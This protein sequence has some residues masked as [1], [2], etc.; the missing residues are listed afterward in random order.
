MNKKILSAV[1]AAVMIVTLM[2]CSA[3]GAIK[4]AGTASKT[5]TLISSE[6][7][8]HNFVK[9]TANRSSLDVEVETPIKA[10]EFNAS[11]VKA[12]KTGSS[13]VCRAYPADMDGYYSFDFSIPLYVSRAGGNLSGDYILMITMKKTSSS[14]SVVCYK[15][16]AF[17]VTDGKFSIL[18]YSDIMKENSR[19]ETLGAKVK[20]SN[21]KK[22]N[23]SDLK[24]LVFKDPVTKKV[25][26]VTTSKV[27]YFKKVADS[28]TKGARTDYDKVLK[29]YEY[30]GTNFYYDTVAF[31]TKTKQYVDPY[32]NLYNM[33]NKKTSNNSKSGKVA[34]T[35][36][37]YAA[38]VVALCRAEGIPAR[39][40]NGHHVSLGDGGFNNWST[41]SGITT[42]DHWWAEA[43]IDGRWIIVDTTPAN[44]NKWNRTTNKWTYTGLTNYIYF[45]PT[46]EQFATSH[47]TFQIKGVN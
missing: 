1:L 15:N 44:S 22:T 21:F 39:V 16:C 19:I 12:G 29:I 28:V 25:A 47:L 26:S 23:M 42:L 36:V 41:E 10:S 17:N 35:C 5:D 14:S 27:K 40:V 45:D 13:W 18:E 43:Y 8:E 20:A 4:S 6:N 38:A 11:I 3:F 34:T 46:P 37:G 30:I 9:V 7:L 31:S 32:R 33:R 2:P 24:S